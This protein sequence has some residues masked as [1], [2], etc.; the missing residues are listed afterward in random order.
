MKK[1][2]DNKNRNRFGPTY[3]KIDSCQMTKLDGVAPPL[4]KKKIIKKMTHDT[5]DMRHMVGVNILS[6]L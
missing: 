2:C 3:Q 1:N 6:K 5:C 4:S